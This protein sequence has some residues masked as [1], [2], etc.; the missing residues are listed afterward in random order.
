[1]LKFSDIGILW[2]VLA[3][4]GLLATVTIGGAFYS[5][6]KMR[7][8][9]DRYGDLLDG[10]GRANLAMARANRNLVYVDRSIYRLLAEASEDKKK[11]ANQEALDAVGYFQKQIKVAMQAEPDE[12]GKISEIGK[13]L[14]TVMATDCAEVLRLGASIDPA[15]EK[16]AS[17]QMRDVCDPALNKEI[18]EISALTNKLL[19]ASDA[20]SDR[21]QQITDE[22]IHSTYLFIFS[23][24][25]LLTVAAA[26]GAR[27]GI[28]KPIKAIA[29]TLEQL[30]LGNM[31]AEV[32]GV[33]RRDEVGM[34][35][36]AALRF[37]DQ[38]L[39][40]LRIRETAASLAAEGAARSERDKEEKMR[41]AA[42]LAAMVQRLGHGLKTLAAGDLTTRLDGHFAG[43]Y[44]Q[45]RDDFDET[46]MRLNEVIGS[47]AA[48]ASAI[49]WG[50]RQILAASED[51]AK[52]AEQQAGT[53]QDSNAAM[54]NLAGAVSQTA[55]ASTRTKDIITTAKLE[56]TE[57]INVVRETEQAI[58]RI[59][60]SSEKIGAIIGVIDE[61]AFQTNLLAL[62]AGVEAARAGETGR[63]FAVV[64]SEV[65]ALAQRSAD[66]AKEI[67]ALVAHS[68]DEVATGVDLVKATGTAFDRIKT[69]V[70]IIDGGIADI[71]GQ[72]VDQSNTLRKVNMALME[73]D[74]T[75]Q[76]NASMAE[77]ATAAC[78]S[79]VDQCVHLAQMVGKF[80]ISGADAVEP[81]PLSSAAYAPEPNA[82]AR[83]A[84]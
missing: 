9:D 26:Y 5:T 84:A 61:I 79:L 40:T 25:F 64:A 7:Y 19:K 18:V 76:H 45:L 36:K 78:R 23:S 3:I 51:L 15:D 27:S 80:R 33:N 35:A 11:E 30:S 72:A 34:L 2:K 77:E 82:L 37:R 67:K 28:S 39:E 69:Q 4:V 68:A 83:S 48:T 22:T 65:R 50:S 62:N 74:Q 71:A 43:D 52:R 75:T 54:Q 42:E 21:T 32:P 47:V 31:H 29:D 56:A 13:G 16:A 6:K 63:G 17:S 66:A 55:D 12:A 41:S 24:L 53:L 46:M 10:F 60:G 20:A 59:K 1:M 70:S 44:A 49:E 38:S 8:I 73:I 58:E 14:E 57:S 81:P